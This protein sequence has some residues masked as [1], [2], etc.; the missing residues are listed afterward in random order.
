LECFAELA[1]IDLILF[2]ISF[3]VE[4]SVIEKRFAEI[5]AVCRDSDLNMD[6]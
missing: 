5:F 1:I 6:A 2:Q 4:Q 3:M